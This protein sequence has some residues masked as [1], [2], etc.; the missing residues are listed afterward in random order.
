MDDVSKFKLKALDAMEQTV[1]S[2]TGEVDKAKAYVEN[3]RGRLAPGA[4][5]AAQP[6]SPDSQ[7]GLARIL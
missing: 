6:A 7:T 5:V 2:L 3:E 4:P 1:N